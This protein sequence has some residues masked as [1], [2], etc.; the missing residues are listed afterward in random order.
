[1]PILV[2]LLNGC[3]PKLYSEVDS[4][5]GVYACE[6]LDNSWD[7]TPPSMEIEEEGWGPGQT[8]PN[9]IMIDQFGEE[10]CLW[11]FYGKVVLIDI[12]AEWCAPCKE[13]AD[14]A[15]AV[16]TDFESQGF[17]YLTILGEDNA[18]QEPNQEVLAKWASDHNLS[19]PV[20]SATPEQ[21]AALIPPGAAYPRLIL[22]DRNQKVIVDSIE[23][24]EDLNIRSAIENAL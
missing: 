24:K 21:R 5:V 11:Q 1:M 16:Q 13:L 22:I 18:S 23:P 15:M 2:F 20:L 4:A 19:I 12:S 10:V 17:I 3:I 14:E 9:Y 6:G 8:V 7:S